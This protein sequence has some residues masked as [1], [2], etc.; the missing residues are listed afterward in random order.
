MYNMKN[1]ILFTFLTFIITG[2]L[3]PS[4]FSSSF[5]SPED[6]PGRDQGTKTANGCDNGTAKNNPNCDDGSNGS[7]PFT[8]CDTHEPIGMIDAA[9]VKQ[10]YDVGG[11]P[12]TL[13]QAQLII[14]SVE[15]KTNDPTNGL[16]D[17]R[18]ELREFNTILKSNALDLCR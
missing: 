1:L 4:I 8:Q 14:D 3:T 9:D 13:A 2:L 11:Y 12:I 5:A 6:A 15:S 16:I 7:D 18:V 10:W 17:T